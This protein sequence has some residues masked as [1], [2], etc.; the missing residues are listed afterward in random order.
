MTPVD[1]KHATQPIIA[2][3]LEL[4]AVHGLTELT[5]RPLAETV[6]MSLNALTQ[7][8]GS[9]EQLVAQVVASAIEQDRAF[10]ESWLER[11]RSLAPV[12]AGLRAVLAETILDHWVTTHRPLACLLID[13]VQEAG[14]Q[15]GCPEALSTW[16]D[17]VGLFWARCCSTIR[18]WPMRRWAICWMRRAFRSSPMPIRPIACCAPCACIASPAASI[19]NR[20]RTSAAVAIWSNGS[21][22]WHPTRPIP[23]RP[24][25]ASAALLRRRPGA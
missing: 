4:I 1:D 13:L 19:P 17:E 18:V 21:P 6:G 15:E 2:S 20:T 5:L 16:L 9:K 7:A 8:M 25:A 10:R 11:L 23:T 3:A 24:T 14:R 12:G 22:R